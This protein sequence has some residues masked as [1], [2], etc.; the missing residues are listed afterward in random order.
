MVF[1]S[2]R[3]EIDRSMGA[4]APWLRGTSR[5]ALS[6]LAGAVALS[7]ALAG[8]ALGQEAGEVEEPPSSP[9]EAVAESVEA[10]VE[11]PAAGWTVQIAAELGEKLGCV[12]VG[13][14]NP[15]SPG[16][17]IVA[18]GASGNVYVVSFRNGAWSHEV[19]LKL[20]G[21]MI[22]CAVG[23]LYPEIPGDEIAVVGMAVGGESAGGAGA[24]HVIVRDGDGWRADEV[25]RSPALLHAVA[26]GSFAPTPG[27]DIM[28][29][30]FAEE[31]LALVRGDHGWEAQ[32]GVRLPGAGKSAVTFR[33]GVAIA[34][35]DGSVV[36]VRGTTAGWVSTEVDKVSAGR[37]RIACDGERLLVAGDDGALVLVA[38]GTSG[39]LYKS[40]DKLRG[41]VMSPLDRFAGPSSFATAGYDGQVVVLR[42]TAEGLR[43][44]V[45][46]SD[47]DRLHHLTA[48]ELPVRADGNALVT[49]GY[50]GRVLVITAPETR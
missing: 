26:I 2:N 15:S 24:A 31:A 43:P 12:A 8:S 1:S 30:G 33:G 36:K 14:V 41:A 4:L 17:E 32:D 13:D 11:D 19:A 48:G 47:S 46:A 3:A 39:W 5:K 37:A 16:N 23:D 6:G 29:A 10:V 49:C 28:V 34:C 38:G 44:V 45:V 9:A 35:T 25:Y 20:P 21:E 27:R 7:V 50:S 22:Q 40:D 42:F 18:L